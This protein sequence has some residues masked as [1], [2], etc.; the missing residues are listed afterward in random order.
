MLDTIIF[1]SGVTLVGN[2]DIEAKAKAIVNDIK[3]ELQIETESKL[4]E[5]QDEALDSIGLVRTNLTE[6]EMQEALEVEDADVANADYFEKFE[7]YAGMVNR[8]AKCERV[9]I[10]QLYTVVT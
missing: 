8:P 6:E 4:V 1:Y 5:I 2:N 9:F 10:D 3:N 7:K